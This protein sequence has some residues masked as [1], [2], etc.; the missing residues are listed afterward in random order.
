MSEKAGQSIALTDVVG[1]YIVNVLANKPDEA[2]IINLDDTS[3][4]TSPLKLN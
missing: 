3:E 2:A 1:D 4:I